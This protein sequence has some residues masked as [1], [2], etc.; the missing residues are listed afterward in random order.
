MAP[1]STHKVQTLLSKEFQNITMLQKLTREQI[2][3]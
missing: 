2:F 3:I 1:V